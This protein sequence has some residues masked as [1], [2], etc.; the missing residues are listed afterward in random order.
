MS[1]CTKS[2]KFQILLSYWLTFK[3]GSIFCMLTWWKKKISKQ[4][5]SL[6]GSLWIPTC[7]G[8]TLTELKRFCKSK[9]GNMETYFFHFLNF[10]TA[11]SQ[12]FCVLKRPIMSLDRFVWKLLTLPK[13][14]VVLSI[15][16]WQ[17]TW[18][19]EIHFFHL[20]KLPWHG[21]LKERGAKFQMNAKI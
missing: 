6:V 4:V 10:P 9:D 13:A 16:D 21:W 5:T 19:C 7:Q 18:D 3:L 2:S 17:T 15:C 11:L 20:L 8:F 1:A 12:I 14:K